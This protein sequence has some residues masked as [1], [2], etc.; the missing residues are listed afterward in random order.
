MSEDSNVSNEEKQ[1]RFQQEETELSFLSILFIDPALYSET[2][3]TSEMF[4]DSKRS[5]IFD[6]MKSLY[7]R[8]VTMD[9]KIVASEDSEID[10]NFAFEVANKI[11]SSANWKWYQDEIRNAWVRD[12]FR[13][14]AMKIARPGRDVTNDDLINLVYSEMDAIN[15]SATTHRI[16]KVSDMMTDYL[17][18]LEERY[19]NR[20]RLPGISTGIKSFDDMTQ[21]LQDGLLYVIGARPSQGKS[22]L[23]LNIAKHV[24]VYEKLPAGILLTEST[25]KAAV[26]RMFADM[27]NVN[28]TKITS[29][30]MAQK[31]FSSILEAAGKLYEA[32]LYIW[33]KS[34]PTI[35]ECRSMVRILI[36]KY[37]IRVLFVDYAQIIKVPGAEDRRASAEEVSM[38]FKEIAQD[39]GL[40]VVLLAQLKR[41]ADDRIPTLGDFQWSSQFEQDADVAALLWHKYKK[42]ELGVID[43]SYLLFEKVRDGPVGARRIEFEKDFVRFSDYVGEDRK[44]EKKSQ[45]AIPPEIAKEEEEE[46]RSSLPYKDD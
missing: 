15:Q 35:G 32:P 43:S 1:R 10:R 4:T 12:R 33:D 29:G 9:Y 2:T 22:A 5:K 21:G 24:S 30:F 14:L 20:G 34:N 31:D 39:E 27:A 36:K 7:D 45:E 42:G 16:V 25:A 8:G 13:G 3:V 46:S 19:R 38:A 26:G 17:G 28:G 18:I 41:D 23:A 40:P 37:K 44:Q 6:V 11:P